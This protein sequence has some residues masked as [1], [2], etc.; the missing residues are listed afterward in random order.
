M[1]PT[2][3]NLDEIALTEETAPQILLTHVQGHVNVLHIPASCQAVDLFKET[4][5]ISPILDSIPNS[6]AGEQAFL[7]PS[8]LTVGAQ[9]PTG[10]YQP[11]LQGQSPPGASLGRL[12]LPRTDPSQPGPSSLHPDPPSKPRKKRIAED[13]QYECSEPNCGN[14][15]TREHDLK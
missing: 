12:L 15:Y 13:G 10:P 5:L 6:Y 9:T 14:R 2:L 7:E 8:V 11:V 1:S 4:D 3:N